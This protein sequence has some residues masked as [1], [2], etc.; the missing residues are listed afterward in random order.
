VE[1]HGDRI[2]NPSFTRVF[3]NP[4]IGGVTIETPEVKPAHQDGKGVMKSLQRAL[5]AGLVAP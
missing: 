4:A 3:S 5:Q 2:I 1:F